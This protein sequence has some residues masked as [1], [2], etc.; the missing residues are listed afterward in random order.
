LTG[1]APWRGKNTLSVEAIRQ[2]LL[3][4]ENKVIVPDDL[5][6][7]LKLIIESCRHENPKKR[8]TIKDIVYNYFSGNASSSNC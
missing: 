5:A 2:N 4:K 8:P 3:E 1:H 6:G 7:P